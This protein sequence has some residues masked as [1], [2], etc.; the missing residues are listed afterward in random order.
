MR[1]WPVPSA[2]CCGEGA[3]GRGK[4]T[5]EGIRGSQG[6]RTAGGRAAQ[7]EAVKRSPRPAVQGEQETA[8]SG[9]QITVNT[10]IT[11][12]KGTS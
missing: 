7:G 5:T 12:K 11:V 9:E 2:A 8:A 6:G 10:A 4:Q 1:P 3:H